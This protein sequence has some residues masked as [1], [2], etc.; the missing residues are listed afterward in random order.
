MLYE[1]MV[2]RSKITN[3]VKNTSTIK[4][5]KQKIQKQENVINELIQNSKDYRESMSEI[6]KEFHKS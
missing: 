1:H 4:N 2:P 3:L 5:L 6:I